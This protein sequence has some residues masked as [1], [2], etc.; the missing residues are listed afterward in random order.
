M[1]AET[2]LNRTMDSVRASH[3]RITVH[4]FFADNGLL[5]HTRRNEAMNDSVQGKIDKSVTEETNHANGG[6]KDDNMAALR[7]AHRAARHPSG[8]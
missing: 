1:T 6:M 2:T 7:A 3:W 8:A 4:G 5:V